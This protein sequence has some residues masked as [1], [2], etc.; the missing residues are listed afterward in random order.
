MKKFTAFTF[1]MD[2]FTQRVE[3]SF[4]AVGAKLEDDEYGIDFD[5][6]AVYGDYICGDDTSYSLD[7]RKDNPVMSD[8]CNK[9]GGKFAG[10]I[11]EDGDQ[12][13]P[14][15]WIIVFVET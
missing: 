7:G 14:D 1:D 6:G 15:G 13:F 10:I 8:F 4:N 2:E 11:S 3:E 5:E 12:E 9:L